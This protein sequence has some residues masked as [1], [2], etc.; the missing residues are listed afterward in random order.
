LEVRERNAS[1][2]DLFTSLKPW[3]WADILEI[4]CKVALR[5]SGFDQGK[6]IIVIPEA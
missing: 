5:I 3:R 1:A 4:H 2:G 6:V